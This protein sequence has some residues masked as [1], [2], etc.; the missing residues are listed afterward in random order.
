MIFRTS[1]ALL[2]FAPMAVQATQI[3]ASTT[4]TVSANARHSSNL[5]PSS[6][7]F[8]QAYQ[9]TQEFCDASIAEDNYWRWDS[10]KDLCFCYPPTDVTLEELCGEQEWVDLM[11]K[12]E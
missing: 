4:S 5:K 12:C 8:V 11:C 1:L 9:A 3:R 6:L 7:R 10:E 2:L